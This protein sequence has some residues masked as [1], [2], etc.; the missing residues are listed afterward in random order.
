MT[1][2]GCPAPSDIAMAATRRRQS[3]ERQLGREPATR[4]SPRKI[5]GSPVTS[6]AMLRTRALWH[7]RDIQKLGL[8][9]QAR[10]L[11]RRDRGDYRVRVKDVGSFVLRP[12]SADPAV[13]SQVFSLLQYDTS[14]FPQHERITAAYGD[15]L[16]RG[17]RPLILDLG[18]NNGASARWFAKQYPRASIV[19]VE[20]DPDNARICRINTTGHPVEVITAAIGSTPGQVNLA[21][22]DLAS[23]SY[24]ATRS[25][26]GE[27]P[28]ITVPEIIADRQP[29]HELFIVKVDIEGFEEDLFARDTEWVRDAHVL[30]IE[31]HDW[32]F[33]D[34]DTSRALQRTMAD[35]PFHVILSGENLIYVRHDDGH[36][37]AD[38]S[39]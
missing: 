29:D 17:H 9:Y 35:L 27:T 22:S 11:H 1:A 8:P 36:V 32:K 34:R 10:H 31:P 38:D 12:R 37:A 16:S 13:V 6:K 28:V 15:I 3:T 21:T 23:V 5:G 18:A 24:T 33:P 39:R 7:A 30:M 20:P 2:V 19:A 26:D 4:L 14:G 25:A